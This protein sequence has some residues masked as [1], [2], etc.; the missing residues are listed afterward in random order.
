MNLSSCLGLLFLALVGA[1]RAPPYLSQSS[2]GSKPVF[3]APPRHAD[4]PNPIPPPQPPYYQ[5]YDLLISKV[6]ETGRQCHYAADCPAQ[7]V[8]YLNSCYCQLGYQYINVSN[9]CWRKTCDPYLSDCPYYFANSECVP[10]ETAYSP[11]TSGH[12]VCLYS[13]AVNSFGLACQDVYQITPSYVWRKVLAYLTLTL[14]LPAMGILLVLG[15]LLWIAY[16]LLHDLRGRSG[17]KK[18]NL[19]ASKHTSTKPTMI[20]AL[21]EEQNSSSNTEDDDNCAQLSS[22]S[23]SHHFELEQ[24]KGEPGQ[25]GA[26]R[27]SPHSLKSSTTSLHCQTV[28]S[29]ATEL[30]LAP[31]SKVYTKYFKNTQ[32]RGSSSPV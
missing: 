20:S 1:S 30:P 26:R 12:C 28:R 14:L 16:L 17:K 21:V 29:P 3:E 11:E 5:R 4:L 6:Q 22:S 2:I 31:I 25:R 8:C 24:L 9:Q 23:T 15:V 7:S 19:S 27:A 13:Y 10:A 18:S 32:I